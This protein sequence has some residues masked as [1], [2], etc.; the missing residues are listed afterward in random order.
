MKD[1]LHEELKNVYEVYI[2]TLFSGPEDSAFYRLSSE[3][4][5]QKDTANY[6]G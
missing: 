5:D 2:I 4:E 1:T 6:S 3:N